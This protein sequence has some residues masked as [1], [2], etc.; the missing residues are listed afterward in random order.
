MELVYQFFEKNLLFPKNTSLTIMQVS[1][2]TRQFFKNN[3][4][5]SEYKTNFLILFKFFSKF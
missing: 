5:V 1:V 4:S 3:T 2:N